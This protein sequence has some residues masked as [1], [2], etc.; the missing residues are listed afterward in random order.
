MTPRLGVSGHAVRMAETSEPTD[1]NETPGD[2]AVA[3]DPAPATDTADAT[4]PAPATDTAG[5]ASEGGAPAKAGKHRGRRIATVVLVIL[6]CVLAPVSLL[7]V[8]AKTTLL[9]EDQYVETVA[10]LATNQAIIDA[11]AIRITDRFMQ[12]TDVSDRLV[13]ALP[14]RAAAAAPAMTQA[15]EGVVHDGAQKILESDQFAQIWEEANRRAH[16]QVVAALTGKK[17]K[18]LEVKDGQVVLDLSPVATRVR[19]RISG[20]GLKVNTK[21]GGRID[22]VIVL[23]DASWLDQV[24]S[25]VDAL[26]KAAWVLPLLTLLLLG[27]GVAASTHRRKTVLRAGLGI[28]AGMAVILL[29]LNLG[30]GPYLDLFPRA[31]GRA[32]GGAAYDQILGGL[33]LDAR[34][35][36]VLGLIIAIGAWL[37]GPGAAATRVRGFVTGRDRGRPAGP[38]AAWVGRNRTGLRIVIIGA[39]VLA[40]VAFDSLSGWVVAGVALVVLLLIALVEFVG[41]SGG[42]VEPRPESE[43]ESESESG[44]ETESETV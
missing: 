34:A 29:A 38:F 13:E 31:E 5:G 36:L 25:G 12:V 39:G 42:A 35:L 32:A 37:A 8:W 10:P 20:L 18:G 14:P 9:D 41:R 28:S 6:G 22:P 27:G 16:N 33:R 44:S 24:Q 2:D 21:G 3:A 43:S 40:L 11:G 4:D 1:A 23:L 7:A 30:R 26:Q 17:T 15:I 19:E